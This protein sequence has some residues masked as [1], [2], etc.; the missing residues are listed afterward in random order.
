MATVR[1]K[2]RGAHTGRVTPAAVA[3]YRAGDWLALHTELRLPPWQVSPL[4]AVGPCPW[5]ASMAGART[6]ADSVALR[7]ELERSHG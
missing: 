4:D 5:P 2:K 6:W 1:R 3:A 7:A